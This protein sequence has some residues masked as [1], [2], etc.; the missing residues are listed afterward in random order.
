[1]YIFNLTWHVSIAPRCKA[2]CPLQM[3]FELSR[4]LWH[5]VPLIFVMTIN[6]SSCT[7]KR[8]TAVVAVQRFCYT[9]FVWIN[10]VSIF[11]LWNPEGHWESSQWNPWL[12]WWTVLVPVSV[13]RYCVIG[14]S[15]IMPVRFSYLLLRSVTMGQYKMI[16]S[17]HII[18]ARWQAILFAASYISTVIMRHKIRR[19]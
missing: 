10:I 12:L 19:T 13:K 14:P 16:F 18:Y 5:T 8:L 6:P 9:S 7:S 17:G 2:F 11:I 4:S 1:M 3:I 15:H